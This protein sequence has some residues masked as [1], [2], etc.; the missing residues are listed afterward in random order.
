[1]QGNDL[2][3]CISQTFQDEKLEGDNQLYC[4]KYYV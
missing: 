4:T 1:M 3:S 2:E